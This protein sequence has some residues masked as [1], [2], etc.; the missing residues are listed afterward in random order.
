[1]EMLGP[2]RGGGG[3]AGAGA[4]G[5]AGGTRR[6]GGGEETNLLFLGGGE[7]KRSWE[8]SAVSAESATR[9]SRAVLN[10]F[11]GLHEEDEVIEAEEEGAKGKDVEEADAAGGVRVSFPGAFVG[12]TKRGAPPRAGLKRSVARDFPLPLASSVMNG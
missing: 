12:G 11:G 3:G 2:L 6:A 7:E 8:K 4:E 5:G 1:M 10:V 9:T